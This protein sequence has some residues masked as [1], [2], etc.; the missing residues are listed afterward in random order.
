MEVQAD[1]GEKLS[2]YWGPDPEKEPDVAA[3]ECRSRQ[4]AMR[5]ACCQRTTALCPGAEFVVANM[6]NSLLERFLEKCWRRLS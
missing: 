1:S 6:P 4:N 3:L 2:A 5:L